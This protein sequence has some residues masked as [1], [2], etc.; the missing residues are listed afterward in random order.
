MDFILDDLGDDFATLVVTLGPDD[1]ATALLDGEV[2]KLRIPLFGYEAQELIAVL[3]DVPE[4]EDGP[5]PPEG[6]CILY[7]GAG[8]DPDDCTTHRHEKDRPEK[9]RRQ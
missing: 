9:A 5:L 6:V 4:G 1:T 8:E 7:G 2:S 3:H